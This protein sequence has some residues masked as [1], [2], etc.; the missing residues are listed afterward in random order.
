M[1][2]R[3]IFPKKNPMIHLILTIRTRRRR[4]R[5]NH[6]KIPQEENEKVKAQ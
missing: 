4:R 1:T 2:S 5:R 3:L 6:T